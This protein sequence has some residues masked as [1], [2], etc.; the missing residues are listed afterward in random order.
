MVD[1]GDI[2]NRN[3]AIVCI[4]KLF[5]VSVKF[6]SALDLATS[7]LSTMVAM[8]P[9]FWNCNDPWGVRP[10]RAPSTR[11]DS[12]GKAETRTGVLSMI[13]VIPKVPPK[14]NFLKSCLKMKKR[15]DP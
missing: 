8:A 3:E 14:M 15:R 6:L 10:G 11:D 2:D 4:L 1:G 9:I 13:D 7:A 12:T 5:N